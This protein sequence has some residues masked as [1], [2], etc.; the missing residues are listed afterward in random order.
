MEAH[1]DDLC[2]VTG[3]EKL[4]ADIKRNF[5]EA[6]IDEKTKA[7]LR[8]ACK[9]THKTYEM[10]E[11]DLVALRDHGFS[12]SAILDITLVA[13]LFNYFNRVADALGIDLEEEMPPVPKRP[14][15]P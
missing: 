13:A 14:S 5:E 2:Q 12:D 6:E 11:A 3:D 10:E 4:A 15:V 9:M 1:G 7:L 8:F